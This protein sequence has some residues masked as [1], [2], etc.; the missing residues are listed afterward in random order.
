MEN[1]ET[2]SDTERLLL[3][4]AAMHG[5]GPH[6]ELTH[7]NT[8]R[9]VDQ[10]LRWRGISADEIRRGWREPEN[11][12]INQ[13]VYD[14]LVRMTYQLPCRAQ[15][16]LGVPLF[17]GGG[18]WG[19]PGDPSQPACWPHYNSCRLTEHGERIAK[20]LLARYPELR[21]MESAPTVILDPIDIYDRG[22]RDFSSLQG[23]ERLVFMLQDFDNLM[24]MEGWDHFFLYE[25]H[26]IWYCEMKEWLHLIGDRASLTVLEDYE[27]HLT[28]YG[29]P[30]SPVGIQN[31]LNTQDNVYLC[32]CP[33]WR[34]QY[35][36][37][38]R[39]RWAKAMA[40]FKCHHLEVLVA[41]PGSATDGDRDA[42]S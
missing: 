35:C 13:E 15:E 4:A 22:L 8:A 17:E 41:E 11:H 5:L 39:D 6:T 37:L 28:R 24:E 1:I 7:A 9:V 30:F 23:A 2:L 14:V 19:V 34:G 29:V 42:G 33:D 26:F 10:V 12:P 3:L 27:R 36:E 31:F 18:N 38:R 20:E 21:L 40:F 25:H 32:E 16:R